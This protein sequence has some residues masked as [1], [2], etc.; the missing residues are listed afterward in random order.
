MTS[1]REKITFILTAIA[2]LLFHL[3]ISTDMQATASGTL[4]QILL[5]APY[6]IGFTYIITVVFKKMTGAGKL[7]WDR[8]L[9]IYFTIAILFAFFFALYEYAGGDEE[10]ADL[11]N[12]PILS[13]CLED[14]TRKVPLYLA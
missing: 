13:G 12:L 10:S 8:Y 14:D 9:R 5:T 6:A 4:Y 2:F 11:K 1:L 7:P 3:R